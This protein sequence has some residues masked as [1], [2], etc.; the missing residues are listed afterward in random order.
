[1]KFKHSSIVV[2]ALF[3]LLIGCQANTDDNME[4]GRMDNDNMFERTGYNDEMDREGRMND[5]NDN[6]NGNNANNN[7]DNNNNQYDVAD[8]AADKITDQIKEIDQ[9]YVLT[10]DNNAYVAAMLDNDSNRN[11]NNRMNENGTNNNQNNNDGINGM[12]DNNAN[13]NNN[14]TGNN[15]GN[16]DELTDDVKSKIKDIVQSV[17]KDIDNVYVTTN[18]DFADLTNNYINDM[19]EG[20]PVRGMFDQIGNAIER[21]FP[22]DNN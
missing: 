5:L 18:P 7:N 20:R 8:K 3:T 16:G 2:A 9:A 4:E 22:Q 19:D 21:I 13:N 11:N 17:D 1:M 15:R 12:F 6:F 10:T 14:N